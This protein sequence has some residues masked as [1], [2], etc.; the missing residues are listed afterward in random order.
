MD[1]IGAPAQFNG[2]VSILNILTKKGMSETAATDLKCLH[3]AV[4]HHPFL[5]LVRVHTR[6]ANLQALCNIQKHN[7]SIPRDGLPPRPSG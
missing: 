2:T 4:S 3:P 1:G 7:A 6:L 5:K